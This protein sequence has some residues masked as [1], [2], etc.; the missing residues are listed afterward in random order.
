MTGPRPP[1]WAGTR[2]SWARWTLRRATTTG[3]RSWCSGGTRTFSLK[4]CQKSATCCRTCRPSAGSSCSSSGPRASGRPSWTDKSPRQPTPSRRPP[5]P[6]SNAPA[7]LTLPRP[8]LRPP[9]PPG[10]RSRTSRGCGMFPPTAAPTARRSRSDGGGG[11]T[12]KR[13]RSNRSRPWWRTGAPGGWRWPA[14]TCSCRASASSM[15]RPS[16]ATCPLASPRRFHF[17]F[18]TAA[19]KMAMA[20]KTRSTRAPK[21]T[22]S[23]SSGLAPRSLGPPR[24]DLARTD[25]RGASKS[26]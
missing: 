13:P 9:L 1:G 15:T 22:S 17:C 6:R 10:P 26:G 21:S 23:V 4:P 18:P 7:A 5:L 8:P 16:A 2:R 11:S 14:A 19:T 3:L 25:R 20:A 12:S 24:L